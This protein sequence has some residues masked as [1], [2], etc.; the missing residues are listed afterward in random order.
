MSGVDAVVVAA[1][2][3]TRMGGVDK[4]GL[5]VGGR[6]VLA[7][8]LAALA[9]APTVRRIVVVTAAAR[10]FEVSTAPWLPSRVV[11][12]VEGGARRQDSVASGIAALGEGVP[13]DVV[14]VH[15]GAR[16]LVSP[17]LVARVAAAAAEHGAAIPVVPVAE[18]L[19]RVV[20]GQITA[21]VDRTLLAA[22]QTPQ[23][24]RRDVL[25][26]A[27]A[28]LPPAGAA[29]WTDEAALLEACRIP[30]HAVPGESTNLKV[31]LPDDLARVEAALVARGDIT[32]P[33]TAPRVGFGDDCHPFG[34]GE[35]LALGGL[36]FEG[37]PR[38]HGHSDGDVALHAVCDALLGA[39][40]LGDLG[41]LF[42]AGP[43]T[44]AGIASTEMLAVCLERVVAA[45]YAPVA[46]DLTVV[47]ARPRLVGRL[48]AMAGM[49]AGLVGI[50][51]DRVNVKASTGNLAGFEG[52]GRGISA[53][54]VAVVAPRG[55]GPIAS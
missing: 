28:E 23:G 30:V 36:V 55:R 24:I 47:G 51:A 40:G 29:T 52:A 26:R 18:T 27:W 41:R 46:I 44:P 34:P 48:D 25:A 33:P 32:L 2:A 13:G 43:A 35:P 54:A 14:L 53:R 7:W 49:I 5:L 39:A 21:T 19:K 6:P 1:G 16:P 31:T 12:V 17:E 9:A 37:A 42:P 45:G 15:D 8:T 3:S 22:A 10:V 20:D 50:A 4:L 11:A 38:L